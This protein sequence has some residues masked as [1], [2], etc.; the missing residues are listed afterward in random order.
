MIGPIGWLEMRPID[1]A[2]C[3]KRVEEGIGQVQVVT[4]QNISEHSKVLSANIRLHD[5]GYRK[6]ISL[7]R[8]FHDV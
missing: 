5:S 6:I 8:F 1:E 2:W 7:A 4:I 3:G